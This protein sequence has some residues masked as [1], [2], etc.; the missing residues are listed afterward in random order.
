MEYNPYY[1]GCPTRQLLDRIANK[2]TVLVLG[3]LVAGPQRFNVLRRSVEGLTQKVL[4]QRLKELERDG[5]VHREARATVPV[6]VEYS[7]TP[8]GR[9]LVGTLDVLRAWAEQNMATISQA[10]AQFDARV[11]ES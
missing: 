8:L 6:T 3:L 1:A 9:T 10:Q 5:L 4:S 2:W 11:K 7:L